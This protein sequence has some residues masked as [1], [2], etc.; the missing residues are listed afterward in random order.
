MGLKRSGHVVANSS[1]SLEEL[2]GERWTC[3]DRLLA[4]AEP[5]GSINHGCYLKNRGN[6]D[7]SLCGF[8]AHNEMSLAFNS[9]W[10]SIRTGARIFFGEPR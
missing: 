7:C 8:T 1:L 9:R 5:D 6:A 10:E 2:K 3:E 4:N